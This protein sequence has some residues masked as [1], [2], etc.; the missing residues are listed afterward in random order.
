M[1][2]AATETPDGADRREE[3]K[4]M[5]MVDPEETNKC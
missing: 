5:M 4:S 3:M 2:M 1:F